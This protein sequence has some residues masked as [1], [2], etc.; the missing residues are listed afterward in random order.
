MDQNDDYSQTQIP[1]VFVEQAQPA[2]ESRTSGGVS[3][4]HFAIVLLV[5]MGALVASTGGLLMLRNSEQADWSQIRQR[6][7]ADR[8]AALDQAGRLDAANTRLVSDLEQAQA[9]VEKYG[10]IEYQLNLI[11]EKTQQIQDL[12]SAKPSY[13]HHLYM[14]VAAV[15]EWSAP[16][17]KLL[18]E[19]VARLDGERAKLIAFKEPKPPAQGPGPGP[20]TPQ[21]TTAPR[22]PLEQN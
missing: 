13:P 17:E 8:L 3:R 5:L 10:A 12:R 6:L 15:P 16:G 20:T 14:N 19:F 4:G 1:S 18:K 22:Q 2:P 11:R 7:E 21:I 9:K